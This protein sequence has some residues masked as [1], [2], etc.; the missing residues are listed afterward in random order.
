MRR[1]IGWL[2]VAVCVCGEVRAQAPVDLTPFVQR[3]RYEQIKISPDGKHF[4]ATAPLEDRTVLVVLNRADKQVVAGGVGVKNSAVWDFWWVDD[5]RLVIS[6]AQTFGS[7][8]PLYA[9]GE[10]HGLTI[11]EK[12][13][14]RLF[15]DKDDVGL[16]AR[17]GAPDSFELATV[18][19]PRVDEPGSVLIATWV[20]GPRRRPRSSR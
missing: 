17:Y 18:I 20:P 11:G 6:M 9:T 7:K 8:D 4:A 16:V 1:S 12:R 3:D 5:E 10:L 14:K 13:I 15:G 19:D 2:L